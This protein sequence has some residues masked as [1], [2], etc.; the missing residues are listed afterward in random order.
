MMN[1]LLYV[2][3]GLVLDWLMICGVRFT[4]VKELERYHRAL[5]IFMWPL[6]I[7][8]AIFICIGRALN[9]S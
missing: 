8:T 9:R 6:I 3:I 2:I 5:I 1:L 7:L 4:K